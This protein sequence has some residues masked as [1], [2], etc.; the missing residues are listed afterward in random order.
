MR[1]HRCLDGTL[2]TAAEAGVEL[3]VDAQRAYLNAP[4]ADVIYE[5]DYADAARIAR[6]FPAHADF[7]AETGR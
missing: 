6:T 3:T 5:I 4:G 7:F 2:G 1:R